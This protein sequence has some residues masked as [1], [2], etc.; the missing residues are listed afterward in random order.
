MYSYITGSVKDI[1]YNSITIDNNGI[2]YNIYVCNPYK[3]KMDSNIKLYIY[4][5]VKE[6]EH[7]LFGFS[8]EDEKKLF[9]KLIEVKGLGP[10][11]TL[12][13]LASATISDIESA[14]EKE[15]IAFIKK[16]PKIG[17]KLAR[18]IILDLKG[19]LNKLSNN[20]NDYIELKS[21]LKALGY[22]I[23]DINNIITNIDKHLSLED[24][25]KQALK[26]LLK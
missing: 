16:F 18:Q 19:N 9:V 1:D 14:I 13:I 12:P 26:L 6:D 15:D 22:K 10:K 7:I 3:Y 25:V 21:T 20:D 24:Q 11:M 4:F 8:T 17:D 2:G 5:H 23:A